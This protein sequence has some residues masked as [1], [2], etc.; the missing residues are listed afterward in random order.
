MS[1][2]ALAGAAAS[3]TTLSARAARAERRETKQ[4]TFIGRSRG[5]TGTVCRAA[6]STGDLR[7]EVDGFG[8]PLLVKRPILGRH[9]K[10]VAILHRS[11]DAL[12]LRLESGVRR[13][14]D[15]LRRLGERAVRVEGQPHLGDVKIG[16]G[17]L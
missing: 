10:R 14:V 3:A 13:R 7:I 16:V 5:T 17:G 11:Q 4:E 15:E 1:P 6:S 2:S 8:F 9:R 12:G